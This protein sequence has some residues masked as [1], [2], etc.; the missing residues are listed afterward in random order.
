MRHVLLAVS[1]AALLAAV[2]AAQPISASAGN[3]YAQQLLLYHNIE[4]KRLG[5]PPLS[6]SS[7][8]A[9]EAKQWADHLARR[10]QLEHSTNDQ[11]GGAGENL[12]MGSAGV[13]S[14]GEMVGSFI[15][16]RSHYRPG[17]FPNVSRTGNWRD[18]GHY[19]QV[20]WGETQEVGCA[21][22]EG[23]GQDFLVCRYWPAGNTYGRPVL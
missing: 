19:T 23:R 4:R 8:L 12:W 2:I 20:I 21:I 17:N 9:G 11:R 6:W 18:V 3:S 7:K 5:A 10:Q 14:A 13:Y 16:E 22:T 1:L 15:S